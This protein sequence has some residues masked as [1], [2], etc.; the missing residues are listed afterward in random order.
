[1]RI[2]DWSSDVCSSDLAVGQNDGPVDAGVGSGDHDV[3]SALR[4]ERHVVTER[5]QQFRRPSARAKHDPLRPYRPGV[6]ANGADTAAA[7]LKADDVALDDP[8]AATP[9]VAGH[10][11]RLP[12]GTQG[13]ALLGGEDG[14]LITPA[15]QRQIGSASCRESG[16][17]YVEI[18]VVAG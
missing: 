14:D 1:M 12:V 2:S 11:Q 16:C 13:H 5:P 15:P 4:L 7:R 17:P 3:I 8:S 18:S 6:G 10:G 9:E